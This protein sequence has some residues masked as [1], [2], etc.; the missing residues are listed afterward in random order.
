MWTVLKQGA[1]GTGLRHP[2][3]FIDI[4]GCELQAGRN[5][6][7]AFVVTGAGTGFH[8]HITADDVSIKNFIGFII[9]NFDQAAFA[10][11]VANSFPFFPGVIF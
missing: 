7:A 6:C 2:I 11:A 9:L 5:Q 10:A 1:V 4:F 3:D 8:I